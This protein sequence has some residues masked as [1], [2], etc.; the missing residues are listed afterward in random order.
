VKETTTI[1][2]GLHYHLLVF[3]NKKLDYAK[4]HK[5]LPKYADINIQLVKKTEEDIKRVLKYMNKN[6]KHHKQKTKQIQ[7]E[8]KQ[9]SSQKI[10]IFDFKI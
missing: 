5:H 1:S 7:N 3:T 8:L 9:S 2:K 10:S 4:V 6:K